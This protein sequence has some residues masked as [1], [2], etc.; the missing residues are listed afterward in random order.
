MS[1]NRQRGNNSNLLPSALEP[2]G[3][4]GE[5]QQQQQQCGFEQRLQANARERY[6]THSVNAAFSTLRQLIPTEPKNRK[7]SKIE[8]LRLAKSYISHLVAVLVTGN[9]QRPCGGIEH[10]AP[11]GHNLR[12]PNDQDEPAPETGRPTIC[13]FCVTFDKC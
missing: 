9:S 2:S 7:L 10:P 13:T 5:Q 8:T 1:R 3:I 6:R 11:S 12:R 4:H